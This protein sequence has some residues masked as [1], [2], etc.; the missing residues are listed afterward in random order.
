MTTGTPTILLS[1]DVEEFDAP[2]ARGRAAH[3][4]LGVARVEPQRRRAVEYGEPEVLLQQV[5]LRAVR[6][7]HGA[8]GPQHQ[9][10]RVARD[11]GRRVAAT[12]VREP[13]GMPGDPD[14]AYADGGFGALISPS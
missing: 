9:Q 5:G 8:V 11:R 6:Q 14:S 7:P 13:K 2:V 10:P 3:P 1:L 4:G 12:E